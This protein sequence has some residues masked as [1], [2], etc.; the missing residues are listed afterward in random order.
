MLRAGHVLSLQ[1]DNTGTIKGDA[2]MRTGDV[3]TYSGDENADVTDY[4]WLPAT[5]CDIVD[6]QG[7]PT[8]RIR[9]TFI[10]QDS[11]MMV[12]RT[13]NDGTKDTLSLDISFHLYVKGVTD[14][15]I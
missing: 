10:A 13:F 3:K 11:P 2:D 8:A 6:G 12:E 1:A 9:A 15:S 4:R 5:G 7:T 14:H